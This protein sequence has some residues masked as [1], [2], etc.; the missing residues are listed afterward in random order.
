MSYLP[1][2]SK[3]TH[4]L[5]QW[6]VRT[7]P[8]HL[9]LRPL[10]NHRSMI[11]CLNGPYFHQQPND[12]L[13]A[14]R[15]Q[16]TLATSRNRAFV[17]FHNLNLLMSMETL[18]RSTTRKSIFTHTFLDQ[19]WPFSDHP[20]L[21]TAY[22][23]LSHPFIEPV[24]DFARESTKILYQHGLFPVG[25]FI[26]PWAFCAAVV[27]LQQAFLH[28]KE[29]CLES[30]TVKEFLKQRKNGVHQKS[31]FLTVQTKCWRGYTADTEVIEYFIIKNYKAFDTQ[32]FSS[33]ISQGVCI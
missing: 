11:R 13:E 2:L 31:R 14:R 1:L 10:H 33:T 28:Y 23:R 20:D 27:A 32:K 16:S 5:T 8:C 25:C 15:R 4:T 21:P 9:L 24:T 30:V 29:G 22:S 7:W 17:T 6:T 3:A 19:R 26:G 18:S 12:R